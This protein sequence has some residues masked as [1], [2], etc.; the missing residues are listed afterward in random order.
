MFTPWPRPFPAPPC[1]AFVYKVLVE[2]RVLRWR[3][4]R[5]PWRGQGAAVAAA[6]IPGRNGAGPRGLAR[7]R[8]SE[9]GGDAGVGG[10]GRDGGAARAVG[11]NGGGRGGAGGRLSCSLYPAGVQSRHAPLVSGSDTARFSPPVPSSLSRLDNARPEAWPHGPCLGAARTCALPPSIK[12]QRPGERPG[13]GRARGGVT[14]PAVPAFE[15]PFRP[16]HS[17]KV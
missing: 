12:S 4:R 14:G 15:L 6:Q 3:R 2:R 7:R 1:A 10:R 16:Y 17:L 8:R 5:Q 11:A 9:A 13:S